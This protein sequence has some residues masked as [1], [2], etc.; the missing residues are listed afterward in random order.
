MYIAMVKFK[1]YQMPKPIVYQK[2]FGQ[3]EFFD[4]F[5]ALFVPN[6]FLIWLVY[7]F[8]DK[9]RWRFNRIHSYLC[10]R[11]LPG[12][13]ETKKP[14]DNP[15]AAM[16]LGYNDTENNLEFRRNVFYSTQVMYCVLAAP[17]V[18]L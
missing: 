13:A 5:F 2:Y 6:I 1:P 8:M 7:S 18:M 16:F 14:T 9:F 15:I 4:A 17:V 11:T 10:S 3:D 12:L